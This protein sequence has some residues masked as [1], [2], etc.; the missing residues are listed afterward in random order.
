[1][2]FADICLLLLGFFVILHARAQNEPAVAMSIRDAFGGRTESAS[3]D[4]AAAGLFEPG[5]AVFR[6]GAARRFEAFGRAART[7]GRSV[8][9]ETAGIDRGTL[10]FDAWELAAAR[11]AA[12]ARAVRAGGLEERRIS[13][14]MR[15]E[16][17]QRPQHITVRTH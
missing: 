3:L 9:V 14:L 6:P 13:L 11:A 5:E 12:V 4:I 17:A 15:P 1:L 2:S 10:R 8:V 7:S 16:A